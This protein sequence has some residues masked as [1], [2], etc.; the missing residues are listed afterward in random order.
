VLVRLP[1]WLGD[2]VMAVPALRLLR[3]AVPGAELWGVGRWAPAVLGGQGLLDHVA[4]P[5]ARWPARLRRARALAP[6]AF[7]LAVVLPNSFESALAA[8]LAGARRR[9][10]YRGDGR[11]ALLTDALPPPRHPTHEVAAY[12]GLL[13]PLGV[14]VPDRLPPPVLR[15]AAA[16]RSAARRLLATAGVGPGEA[17]VGI[18]LGAA[19]GPSKLWDPARTATV[20]RALAR[21]GTPVVF[22]GTAAAAPLLEAVTGALGQPPRSLVGRDTPALLPALLAE[23]DALLSPDSGPA[24]VAAAVGTPVVTL[25]GP[26]DPRRSAPLGPGARVVC[27]P[28]ACAPCHRPRCPIDHRCLTA[29]EPEEVLS[30]VLAAAGEGRARRAGAR[31]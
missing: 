2:T 18:Q 27:H 20:A 24:H 5:G 12:L 25:F 9:I 16:D 30:A 29:V 19:L 1:S 7:D 31:A 21:A 23:L 28:P 15:V 6:A 14:A 11:A 17:P 26:T 10:G 3:A 4:E 22:L 13:A 8:W